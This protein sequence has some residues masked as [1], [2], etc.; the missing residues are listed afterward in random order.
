M[1]PRLV[2]HPALDPAAGSR[3]G[4]GI[5]PGFAGNPH[6]LFTLSRDPS[7]RHPRSAFA[8]L[9][10]DHL[11]TVIPPPMAGWTAYAPEFLDHLAAR[12]DTAI[13]MGLSHGGTFM[14]HIYRTWRSLPEAA[15]RPRHLGLVLWSVPPTP[16]ELRPLAWLG[17]KA[18]CS[19][20]GM[21]VSNRLMQALF[22]RPFERRHTSRDPGLGPD[23]LELW[24]DSVRSSAAWWH[25]TLREVVRA[26]GLGAPMDPQGSVAALNVPAHID[27]ALNVA[28]VMAAIRLSYPGCPNFE[29]SAAKRHAIPE[30]DG[31]I[32]APVLADI[33]GYFLRNWGLPQ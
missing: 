6:L 9:Q 26:G 18:A 28:R 19:L 13:L 21:A 15:R 22:I 31:L 23:I 7:R 4:W 2:D 25:H 10:H 12:A 20:P 16:R 27:D 32:Y 17:L 24:K 11:T 3:I 8:G 33:R 30:H 5:A 1:W 14:S 29:V